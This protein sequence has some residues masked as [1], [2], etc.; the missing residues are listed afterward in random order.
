MALRTLV[1]GLM[2]C[3]MV[4]V[5]AC[6]LTRVSTKVNSRRVNFSETA[7][8]HGTMV[9]GMKVYGSTVTCTDEDGKSVRMVHYDTTVSG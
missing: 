7:R 6:L 2:G 3:D 1:V 4:A 5:D 9:G 8:C